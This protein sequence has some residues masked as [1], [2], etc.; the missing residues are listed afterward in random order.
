MIISRKTLVF[1]TL[2]LFMLP[3]LSL[4]GPTFQAKP[5]T[6]SKTFKA[7]PMPQCAQ[8][9]TVINKQKHSQGGATWWTYS[10]AKQQTVIMIC[11]QGLNITNMNVSATPAQPIEGGKRKTIIRSSYSCFHMEG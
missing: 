10:C 2:G 5:A 1:S 6:P 9:Y 7:T 8:G 11:N 3:L 4:A